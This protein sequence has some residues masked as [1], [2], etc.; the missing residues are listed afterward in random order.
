MALRAPKWLIYA[1]LILSTVQW[2]ISFPF[3]YIVLNEKSA[4]PMLFATMRF[5]LMIPLIMGF[6]LYRFGWKKMVATAKQY[7]WVL[8]LFGL[9]N[10]ALSNV[11]QN[12]GMT[13]TTPAI[14]SIIQ[15]TGPIFVIILAV[16]FLK[17]GITK[18]KL[19][20]VMFTVTGS[21]L[22]IT[23]GQ[24]NIEWGSFLGNLLILASAVSYAVS[25]VIAKHHLA[26]VNPF[27]FVG[28][29]MI[30]GALIL[31]LNSIVLQFAG[32][33]SFGAVAS[34]DT[35]TWVL[36]IFLTVGPGL[37]ALFAWYYLLE[38]MQISRQTFFVYLVPI[39]GILFSWLVVND[40]LT[41]TQAIFTIII[42]LGV[43]IS[44]L[45]QEKKKKAPEY[46]G[47]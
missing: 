27:L 30:A 15:T 25:S 44:Q 7:W 11:F 24:F 40:T 22:L 26:K 28:L 6:L 31:L 4:P 39:F 43:V 18:Y 3:F 29:G 33:E 1:A 37:I 41:P 38:H 19:I 14:S 47:T 34:F 45:G 20:G 23:G 35:E 16:L 13:L 32:I 36:L 8:I 17:E 46:F 10:A 2:G 5:L 12:I 21:L 42:I 9:M